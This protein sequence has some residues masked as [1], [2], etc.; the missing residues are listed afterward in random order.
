MADGCNEH[1]EHEQHDDQ[2]HHQGHE[3]DH[4]AQ[5]DILKGSG[6]VVRLGIAAVVVAAIVQIYPINTCNGVGHIVGTGDYCIAVIAVNK[7]TFHGLSEGTGLTFQRGVA[8]AVAVGHVVIAVLVDGRF[9]HQ[10]DQH[11]VVLGSRAD[12]PGVEGLC[13]IILSGIITR[14]IYSQYADLCPVAALLQLGIQVDDGL[15]GAVAQN[16]GVIHHTLISGQVRQAGGGK[17]RRAQGRCAHHKGQ[18]Q[19]A[20]ALCKIF[21]AKGSTSFTP[22]MAPSTLAG[23]PPV[24]FW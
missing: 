5:N 13:C 15:G 23:K 16:V 3:Q 22:A 9:H 2:H 14:I 7:I 24:S 6:A 4:D 8:E 21:H 11:T 20:H 18:H 19:S 17:C 12:A 1:P 10:Q